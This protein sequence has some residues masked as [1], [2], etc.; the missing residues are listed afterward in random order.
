MRAQQEKP[1]T[2]NN[3]TLKEPE[4]DFHDLSAAYLQGCLDALDKPPMSPEQRGALREAV[5]R[6][7]EHEIAALAMA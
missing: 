5:I 1:M 6:R 3:E 7:L 2:M 4:E